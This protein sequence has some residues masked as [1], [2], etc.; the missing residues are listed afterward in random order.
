MSKLPNF[1][2][3]GSPKCGST[4]LFYYLNEHPEIFMAPQKEIHYFSSEILNTLD[5]GPKDK[6][7]NAFHINNYRS[8]LNQF[9]KAKPSQVI[10]EVSPSYINY[11]ETTI[12]KI[13]KHLG[14][15]KIIVLIRDPVKRAYSNYF[16]LVREDRE[17]LSFYEALKQEE[18]RMKKKYSDFWYYRFNS[19][20][21]NKI[22]K[23]DDAF[24][25]ILILTT[26]SLKENTEI[27]MKLIYNFLEVNENFR[28]QN[29]QREYNSGGVYKSNLV[30]NFFFRQSR[31]RS[32]IK[33]M[34]PITAEMKQM[35]Q[36]I[37][38]YFKEETPEM[39]PEAE[40]FLIEYFKE[41]VENLKNDFDIDLTMWNK[42]LTDSNE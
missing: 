42:K 3:A 2:V 36:K 34:I 24:D 27:T 4:S 30:T 31:L 32:F 20:Y 35:K 33:K 11:P 8:Y 22:K 12:P 14:N 40:E 5:Q 25:E 13:K 18:T 10:G 15:P 17:K 7:V 37:L 28:T 9:K 23:F 26:E 41:D 19:L 21:Y 39:K 1:L 6:R 16:H 29:I 38:K